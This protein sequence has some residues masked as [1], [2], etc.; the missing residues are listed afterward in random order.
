MNKKSGFVK[1]IGNKWLSKHGTP[2]VEPHKSPKKPSKKGLLREHSKH[3]Y[4]DHKRVRT[5]EE[6][7]LH[8]LALGIVQSE[9]VEVSNDNP[10]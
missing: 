10:S 2:I 6:Q 5:P 3:Y 9:V 1:T 4:A 7:A 8:N